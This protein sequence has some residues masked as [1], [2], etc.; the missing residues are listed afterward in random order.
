MTTRCVRLWTTKAL[1]VTLELL[2]GEKEMG[3]VLAAGEGHTASFRDA[4][5]ITLNH[6]YCRD[7]MLR[8]FRSTALT[9]E[10]TSTAEKSVLGITGLV[11]SRKLARTRSNNQISAPYASSEISED[12]ALTRC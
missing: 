9:V 8:E 7:L 2:P 11:G 12:Q 3:T 1:G 10:S 4:S 5:S 6:E